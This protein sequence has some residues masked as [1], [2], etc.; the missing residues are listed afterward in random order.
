MKQLLLIP[1]IVFTLS[2]CGGLLPKVKEVSYSPWKSFEEAKMAYDQIV[3]NHTTREELRQLGYDPFTTPNINILTYLDIAGAMPS[4]NE[5]EWDEG[6]LKCVKAA[7]KCTGYDIEPKYVKSQRY[8]NFWLD[9]FNFRRKTKETGW[10]FKA[11]V[12]LVD[13]TVVYKLWGGNPSVS[14][15]TDKTNPLGPLQD[16]GGALIDTL[17]P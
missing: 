11:L 17:N 6:L 9:L 10:K 4:I 14:K 1:I 7:S 12:V 3:I 13:D 15:D 16:S 5:E 8:G 2:A